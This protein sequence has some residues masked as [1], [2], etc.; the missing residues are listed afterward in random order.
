MMAKKHGHLQRVYANLRRAA[1]GPA[2]SHRPQGEG[3]GEGQVEVAQPSPSPV[4]AQVI[5]QSE[6]PTPPSEANIERTRLFFAKEFNLT[7]QQ[8]NSKQKQAYTVGVLFFARE[9]DA[10][11]KRGEERA[12]RRGASFEPGA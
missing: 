4:A 10:A 9:L 5:E 11:E 2:L 3:E 8:G 1:G 12:L 6:A 7:G